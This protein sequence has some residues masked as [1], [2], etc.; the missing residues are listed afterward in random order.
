MSHKYLKSLPEP[1]PAIK[2]PRTGGMRTLG[3]FPYV[4][5]EC[6]ANADWVAAPVSQCRDSDAI[7]Q[8]NFDAMCDMLDVADPYGVDWEIIRF[9]HFGVGWIDEIFARPSSSAVK[10]LGAARDALQKDPILDAALLAEYEA[11]LILNDDE[12]A[13]CSVSVSMADEEFANY[14]G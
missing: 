14:A 1:K 11:G 2:H 9:G 13:E 8:A 10:A 12:E 3:D 7:E 4:N 6:S 5:K